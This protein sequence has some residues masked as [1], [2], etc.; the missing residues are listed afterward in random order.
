MSVFG[1]KESVLRILFPLGSEEQTWPHAFVSTSPSKKL[2]VNFRV[3]ER[4]WWGPAHVGLKLLVASASGQTRWEEQPPLPEAQW[5]RPGQWPG[6]TFPRHWESRLGRS[7]FLQKRQCFFFFFFKSSVA[8]IGYTFHM[9][10]SLEMAWHLLLQKIDHESALHEDPLKNKCWEIITIIKI[11]SQAKF[12]P[13]HKRYHKPH[14]D[15]FLK[16][17]NEKKHVPIKN[18]TNNLLPLE[19]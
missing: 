11:I 9:I 6:T 1:S 8:W 14:I 16:K 18:K 17:R 15:F 7:W 2:P 3:G 12:F 19:H 5:G 13:L 10:I 4:L